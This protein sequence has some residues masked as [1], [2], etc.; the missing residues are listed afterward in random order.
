MH[1]FCYLD[2]QIKAL[3]KEMASQLE[4]DDLGSRLLMIPCVGPITASLLS[5]PFRFAMLNNR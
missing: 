1:D 3:D 2:E 5:G 4:E